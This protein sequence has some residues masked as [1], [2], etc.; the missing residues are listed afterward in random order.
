MI[1][2]NAPPFRA[3]RSALGEATLSAGAPIKRR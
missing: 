2:G 1:A 3:L